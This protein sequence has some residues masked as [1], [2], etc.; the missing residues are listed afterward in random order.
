VGWHR[1]IGCGCV[2][3]GLPALGRAQTPASRAEVESRVC[4][5]GRC[6]RSRVRIERQCC[7]LAAVLYASVG[8]AVQ[9]TRRSGTRSSTKRRTKAEDTRTRSVA[10]AKAHERLAD[11]PRRHQTR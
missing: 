11:D 2:G 9:R 10:I 5:M 4:A 8:L 3:F 6:L 7:E 1:L